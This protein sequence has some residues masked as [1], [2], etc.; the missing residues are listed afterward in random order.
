MHRIVKSAPKQLRTKRL[1]A[2]LQFTQ[3]YKQRKLAR[4]TVEDVLQQVSCSL[5]AI[6]PSHTPVN[7]AYIIDPHSLRVCSV[8]VCVQSSLLLMGGGDTNDQLTKLGVTYLDEQQQ[9]FTAFPRIF[10]VLLPGRRTPFSRAGCNSYT[11][12]LLHK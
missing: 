2:I 1:Y 7:G 6:H 5:Q 11:N 9:H 10:V 4:T 3:K 12:H 8:C